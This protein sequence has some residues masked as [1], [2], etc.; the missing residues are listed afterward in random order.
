MKQ[1]ICYILALSFFASKFGR[2]FYLLVTGLRS[3]NDVC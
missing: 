3:L 1:H 2:G